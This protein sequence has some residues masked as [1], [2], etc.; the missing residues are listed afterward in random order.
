[1]ILTFENEMLSEN[2]N[3]RERFARRKVRARTYIHDSRKY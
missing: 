3:D 2:K 1:M